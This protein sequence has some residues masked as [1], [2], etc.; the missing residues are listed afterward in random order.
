MA[1]TVN[2]R[3]NATA[4]AHEKGRKAVGLYYQNNNFA[5]ATG[6]QLESQCLISRF[7]E[8]VNRRQQLSFS[9]H[10]LK[11]LT[12]SLPECLMEF[13]KVTLTFESMDEIL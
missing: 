5:H 8:N 7:V 3:D 11:S 12:L 4:T 2:E 10:G 1:A 9:F 6:L 13:C